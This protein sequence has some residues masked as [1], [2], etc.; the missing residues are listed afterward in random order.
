MTKVLILGAAV[1]DIIIATDALPKTGEDV[2]A[3]HKQS[4]VGGCAYNVA[5][6]LKA[7]EIKSDL[8]APIGSGTYASIIKSNLTSEGYNILIEDKSKDNGWNL[9]LVE[10]DG[11]RTFITIPGIETNWKTEWFNNIDI[12]S[13][14][15]I[16][17]SGY[18]LE[19]E[20]G[21][22][23]LEAL[24][25]KKES[26]KILFDASPRISFL[27]KI[28]VNKLLK[29]GTIY[30][31]NKSELQELT[32]YESPEKGMEYVHNLTGEAVIV[33]LGKDGCGYLSSEEKGIVET[34]RVKVVDTIGAGD[35]H[36]GGLIA[37]IVKKLS[38]KESCALA[39]SV[40]AK[41]VKCE[42]G[43]FII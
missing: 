16:Y 14:D 26:C 9:S 41:V 43:K 5:N 18:E 40:A 24:K 31:S 25:G 15:L 4:L 32:G 12:A 39:N 42:G 3:K 23:I 27:D 38:I 10:K 11:E 36:T 7:L 2:M 37:G 22:V 21:N 6:V 28:L 1:L 35:A 20:S 30:H 19:G 13:Y 29:M 33:T 8:F 34:Q 17:V